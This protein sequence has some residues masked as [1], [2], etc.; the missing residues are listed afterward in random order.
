M[1]F[2]TSIFRFFE[3]IY[4]LHQVLKGLI[5]WF[6]LN[7]FR[8]VPLLFAG[9]LIPVFMR[10]R[11]DLQNRCCPVRILFRVGFLFFVFLKYHRLF[12]LFAFFRIYRLVLI[13]FLLLVV[14]VLDRIIIIAYSSF[15]EVFRDFHR[16]YR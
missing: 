6:R 11:P 12:F 16:L 15:V 14:T 5:Y 7:C 2:I 13:L 3:Q 10:C 4:P 9:S 8:G 1:G